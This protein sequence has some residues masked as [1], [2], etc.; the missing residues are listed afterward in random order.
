M[1]TASKLLEIAAGELGTKEYPPDSNKV[2]YTSWY[3]MNAQPWC[4]MFVMWVFAQAGVALPTRTASCTTL[5]EAAKRAGMWVT[6]NY[7]PG[8]VVIYDWGWDKK[9]DHCGIVK[10]VYTSG[11]TAIEGNTSYDDDS[12]GGE[13]MLRTRS[14]SQILGAVRS[15]FEEEQVL[16]NVSKI[17]QEN[18]DWM[19]KNGI[20]QGDANGDLKLSSPVTRD[21]LSAILRRYHDKFGGK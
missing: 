10:D 4:V 20:M 16:D 3:G 5:M 15:V 6:G 18:V 2:K 19:V 11:I 21:A 1:S 17:N 9:P 13:V 8:D 12:N 14:N 7:K